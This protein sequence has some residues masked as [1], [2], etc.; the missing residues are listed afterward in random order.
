[1]VGTACAAHSKMGLGV[2]VPDANICDNTA[3]STLVILHHNMN[4]REV[5]AMFTPC[6]RF[7]PLTKKFI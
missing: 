4:G 7:T 5:A 2:G 3:I 6:F 1:M